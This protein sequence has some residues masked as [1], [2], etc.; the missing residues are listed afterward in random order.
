MKKL[1]LIVLLVSAALCTLIGLSE[2]W[3]D[4]GGGCSPDR[5]CVLHQWAT[6]GSCSKTCGGGQVTQKRNIK[7][8]SS[9]N[10]KRCPSANSRQRYRRVL[11][12]TQCCPVNCAWTWTAWSKCQG[13]GVSRQTRTILIAQKEKC[14][15]KACPS[16]RTQTRSCN[17][18]M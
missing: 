15:G 4:G 2:S 5:D 12:N 14:G 9:C 7:A 1:S 16:G 6:F 3:W 17:T 18:G 13:C 11:C 10:G 8:H